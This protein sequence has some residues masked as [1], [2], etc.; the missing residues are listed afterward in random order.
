MADVKRR[1]LHFHFDNVTIAHPLQTHAFELYQIGDLSCANAYIGPVHLQNCYE[2]SYIMAGVGQFVCDNVE[3]PVRQGDVFINRLGEEHYT[4]SS[5]YDPLRFFYVG[6]LFSSN[7]VIQREYADVIRLFEQRERPV[8]QDRFHISSTF[9]SMFNEFLS[10]SPLK[11]LVVDSC[12]QQLVCM[13]YRDFISAEKTVYAQKNKRNNVDSVLYE[14]INYVDLNIQTIRHLSDISR[15]L[16]YSYS[17]ISSVFSEEMGMTL[18]VY[19]DNKKIEYAK[20]LLYKG[21]VITD[22]AEAMGYDSV[23]TFSR[24]FKRKTGMSP[25]VYRTQQGAT[26]PKDVET[27]LQSL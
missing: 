12:L 15:H 16:G 24:V 26:P 6:F 8:I 3:Y 7:P 25:T 11:E 18:K 21:A 17:Y 2:I 9:L 4:K 23:H 13:T 22:V 5:A 14:I 20:S 19:V 27:R 10:D 1:D